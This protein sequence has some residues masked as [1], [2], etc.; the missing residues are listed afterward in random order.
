M[1][2]FIQSNFWGMG[3][4]MCPPGLGFGFQNRGTAFAMDPG[5]ANAYAPGKAAL[6][7]N[8]SG[9]HHPR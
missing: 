8:H 6:S 7:H 1:V 3:S 9:L 5:H 4:G 2:S